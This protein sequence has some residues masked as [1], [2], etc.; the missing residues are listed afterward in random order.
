MVGGVVPRLLVAFLTVV[1]LLTRP[2]PGARTARSRTRT[3]ATCTPTRRIRSTRS[4]SAPE[5]IRRRL[6][7]SPP[8]RRSTSQAATTP[9]G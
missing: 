9:A 7:P 6:T 2:P 4:S 3:S 1:A 5:R 8:A